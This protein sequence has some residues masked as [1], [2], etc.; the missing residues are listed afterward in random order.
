MN[1]HARFVI[2]YVAAWLVVCW[3]ALGI[4]LWRSRRAAA[5]RKRRS[6]G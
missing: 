3:V 6:G 5:E 4:A 2:V 1:W